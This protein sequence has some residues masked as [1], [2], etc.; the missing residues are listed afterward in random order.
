LRNHFKKKLESPLYF[1]Y[2]YYR[3][4]KGCILYK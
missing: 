1:C 2:N 4:N 3:N